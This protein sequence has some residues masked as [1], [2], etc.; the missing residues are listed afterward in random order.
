MPV[1][2]VNDTAGHECAHG[3][4]QYGQLLHIG[5]FQKSVMPED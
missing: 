1:R 2:L 3:D 4:Q 5:S